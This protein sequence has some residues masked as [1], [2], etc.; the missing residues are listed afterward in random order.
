MGSERA[1]TRRAA[2]AT[3]AG[4]ALAALL[5]ACAAPAATTPFSSPSPTPTAPLA[6]PRPASPAA[7]TPVD[8]PQ[9]A[10]VLAKVAAPTEVITGLP[11][12]G[13]LLAWTVDDGTSSAVVGAYAAFAAETGTRLTLFATGTYD[14]WRE[15]QPALQPLVA[16]GQVQIANH[17]WSHPDL[18][19]LSD[20]GILDELQR[21]HDRIGELFDVDARPFYRPPFGYYDDRVIEVAASIGYTAPTLWYGSLSDSGLVSEDLIVELASTWFLPQHIV[22]GHLNFEPVTRVFPQLHA[23][24][25]ERGL[26][27]VTLNDVYTSDYHP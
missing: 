20:Q 17:T 2:L 16:S 7:P 5:A 14:S 9:A 1:I 4:G 24:V 25:E 18:T 23:I 21:T 6:R 15:Q 11:G 8:T 3:G 27:T 10:P 26:T 12:E 22:I 19:S 13:N